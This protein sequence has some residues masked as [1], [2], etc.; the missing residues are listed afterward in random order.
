MSF[1]NTAV[2]HDRVSSPVWP[3]LQ[4][5]PAELG[6]T[7][8]H[9]TEWKNTEYRKRDFLIRCGSDNVRINGIYAVSVFW[10]RVSDTKM[11]FESI[12]SRFCFFS[13]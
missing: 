9:R 11:N 3:R 5:R 12:S 2:S 1:F 7:H 8:L 13:C 4:A 10:K 6:M